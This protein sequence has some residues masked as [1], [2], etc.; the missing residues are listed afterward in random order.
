M[1]SASRDPESPWIDLDGADNIRDLGGLPT[2]D[3]GRIRRRTLLRSGTLQDLTAADVDLLVD[4]IGV[5]TV[6]D[7]RLVDEVRREGSALLG[8]DG[9]EYLEL[10]LWWDSKGRM[11]DQHVDEKTEVIEGGPRSDIVNHYFGYLAQGAES[12]RQSALVMADP[13][14][15]PLVFNCA[16]GKDRT[17]VLAALVLDAVGVDREAIVADYALSGERL[18][19]IRDHL[20]R[21]DTY[22]EMKVVRAN[23]GR[24]MTAEPESMRRLLAH[25]DERWGGAAGYLRHCGLT[26][27]D[28]D[29]LRKALVEY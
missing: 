3:G 14:K 27:T 26:D 1:S 22:R 23:A 9:V 16:A 25:V 7:L 18:G 8:I 11:P 5:K 6:I 19:R 10:P 21:L 29:A 28:L 13:D 24:S 17:G 15:T 12:V 2:H 4:E 20:M